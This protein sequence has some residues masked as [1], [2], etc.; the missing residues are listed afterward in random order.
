M[1]LLL[2]VVLALVSIWGLALATAKPT[3]TTLRV[4]E[5]VMGC[6]PCHT[7]VAVVL[8]ALM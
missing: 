4:V 7:V 1:N 5:G 3:T 2:M 8:S 6:P